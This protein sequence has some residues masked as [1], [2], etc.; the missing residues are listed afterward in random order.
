MSLP[1]AP[2]LSGEEVGDIHRETLQTVAPLDPLRTANAHDP[3]ITFEEYLY[4]AEIT[5]KEEEAAN[6]LYLSSRG[7]S[8]ITTLVAS[9]FSKEKHPPPTSTGDASASEK[10]GSE[11]GVSEKAPPAYSNG[12]NGSDAIVTSVTEHEWK[13][14]SRAMRTAGWGGIFYL[15][16]TDI[17]GPFSAPWAF[18]QMGYGPGVALYTVFGAMSYYSGWIIW[19]VFLGLDSDRHPLRGYGD[20][21]Y[22]VFGP[23]SR[24]LVNTALG[25][26]LLL[27]VSVIILGNGQAIS[28]ISKGPDGNAGICF[29]ACLIIFMV[30]GFGLGQIR[31]L[32][33]FSWVAHI[34]VYLNLLVMFIVMGVVVNTLP[35]F[36]ATQASFGETFG[37]GPVLTFGGTPPDGLASGGSGFIG[38]LNG[39][40]QAVYSYGGCMVFAAFL[41]E[42]RHPHDFWKSLLI[43]QVFI[44]VVYIF[45]GIFVYS[46]QGQ[47]TFNPVSQ[48]LSV[49]TWQTVTNIILL[50]TSLIAAALYGNIGLKV[51]Y[52]EVFQEVFNAP[53]LTVS[54]GKW[55]WTAL[56]PIYWAIAFV[57]AAAV[58]Q[59]PAISGFIGAL[60]ILNFTYTLP[61]LLAMG[62]WIKKDAIVE[63]EQFDP[64]TKTFNFTDTGVKRWVRG[65]MKRPIYNT[66]NLLYMLGGAATAVLGVYS[67]VEQ[68]IAAFSGK[69]AATSFGCASPV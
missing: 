27:F 36:T 18:A 57:V 7:P 47:Y 2:M 4:W 13:Q 33:R 11:Q 19:K 44:Y 46:F 42:M 16:T 25:L 63:G 58:P 67:S 28:Q 55:L 24:H 40:N 26:Q 69:S 37:P 53:P 41:S 5:R 62:F 60:F 22:R 49:Y 9:R 1:P 6:A 39:L 29:V 3:S 21:Y 31:S 30:A 56:I 59:L 51:L 32:R 68:L 50:V 43:A 54:R 38:S 8:T 61:A 64:T 52:I 34:S 17:L 10:T 20:L 23:V 66:W 45:F 12:N 48:G 65:Y 15:I 35:N 14:A